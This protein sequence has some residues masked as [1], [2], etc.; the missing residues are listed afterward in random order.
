MGGRYDTDGKH[1]FYV[2]RFYHARNSLTRTTDSL[3]SQDFIL[4]VGKSLSIN[5]ATIQTPQQEPRE[6]PV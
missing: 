2:S 5:A 4:P 3:L 1:D 6:R